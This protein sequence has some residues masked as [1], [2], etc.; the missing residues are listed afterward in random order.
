MLLLMDDMFLMA[1]YTL[2]MYF[3][4]LDKEY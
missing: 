1:S 2:F 4:L 3:F